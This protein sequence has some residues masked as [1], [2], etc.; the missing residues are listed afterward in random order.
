[1]GAITGIAIAA[2]I[3]T[4]FAAEIWW[5]AGAIALAAVSFSKRTR[6]F[7]TLA[8]VAGLSIGLWRGSGEQIALRKYEHYYDKQVTL[9][10]IVS[11]DVSH[12][13][14]GD[15]R[16]QLSNVHING[17]P[18]HGKVWLSTKTKQEIKRSDRLTLQGKL[19]EGFGNI[20]ASLSN[21]TLAKVEPTSEND[22]ALQVRDWFADGVR[23]AIPEPQASLGSGF[24]V[25]QH[26]TLPGELGEELRIVGLTHAVVASG[27]NLTILVGFTRRLLL[28]VSKYTATMAGGLM[29]VGFVMVTG[30]S[31]SMTRAGLVTGLSLAAWYYGRRINPL[32]LLPYAAGITAL[33]N[34]SYIW[35]D[36]GWYLSFGAFA[37]V[38]ILAPLLQHY[39]WGKD[40]KPNIMMEILIGTTAA[41]IATLPVILFSFGTFSSYALIANML[42]L[43]LIPFAM[44]LTFAAGVAGV[45]VPAIAAAV[46]WPATITMQYMT[47]VIHWVANLPGAQGLVGFTGF[48]LTLSYIAMA[49]ACVYMWRKTSHA[50]GKETNILI[51][52]RT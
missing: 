10:G 50:F 42:V 12:G 27:S 30:L 29:T 48:A 6:T 5:L 4:A 39:F 11:E 34:P 3:E 1:M 45:A 20:P 8:L 23:L 19:S 38:L 37:G 25:G 40:Y 26:T 14:Q 47:A 52:E 44:L 33:A 21:A 24:I 18:L 31:P 46:G 51:G 7:V 17:Q 9:Q 32:V 22:T 16:L 15:T 41:Q 49:F 2:S 43:P 36:I 13:K 28:R 35:G